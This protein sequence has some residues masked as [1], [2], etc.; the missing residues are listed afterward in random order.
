MLYFYFR[1]VVHD[2]FLSVYSLGFLSAQGGSGTELCTLLYHHNYSLYI[3]HYQNVGSP[4]PYEMCQGWDSDQT[5]LYDAYDVFA[6]LSWYAEGFISCMCLRCQNN[7]GLFRNWSTSDLPFVSMSPSCV[8]SFLWLRSSIRAI[9]ERMRLSKFAKRSSP[10][11][12][13]QCIF[14]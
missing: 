13:I 12:F 7:I 3:E 6:F 11:I 9:A 10:D 1:Q 2:F 14:T 8:F 5:H 4:I